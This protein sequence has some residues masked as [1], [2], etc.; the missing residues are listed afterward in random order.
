MWLE[1]LSHLAQNAY[2]LSKNFL[3]WAIKSL[4]NIAHYW[5]MQNE[6][7]TMYTEVSSITSV[8]GSDNNTNNKRKRKERKAKVQKVTLNHSV[9]RF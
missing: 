6:D 4:N 7:I 1:Y 3:T 5:D 8:V 9:N 2:T